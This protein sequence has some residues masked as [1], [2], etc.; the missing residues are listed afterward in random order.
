MEAYN[1][2]TTAFR[3]RIVYSPGTSTISCPHQT[4]TTR[5]ISCGHGRCCCG[6]CCLSCLSSPH[7]LQAKTACRSPRP[8]GTLLLTTSPPPHCPCCC[9]CPCPCFCL[10]FS[11]CHPRRG[12]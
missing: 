12:P 7:P 8:A 10:C 11:F 3:G 6:C 4:A 2:H 5:R 9:P 1:S